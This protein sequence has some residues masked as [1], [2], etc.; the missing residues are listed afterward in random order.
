MLGSRRVQP[1]PTTGPAEKK[2]ATIVHEKFVYCCHIGA[3][4]RLSFHGGCSRVHKKVFVIIAAQT[5]I[6]YSH[7]RTRIFHSQSPNASPKVVLF[8]F[9]FDFFS[10]VGAARLL[11]EAATYESYAFNTYTNVTATEYVER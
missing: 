5:N 8:G 10:I 3:A 2:R 6:G 11:D 9:V 7:T 1:A 4:F